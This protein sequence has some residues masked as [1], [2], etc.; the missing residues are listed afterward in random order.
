MKTPHLVLYVRPS[1]ASGARDLPALETAFAGL[2]LD[3]HTALALEI[4][5]TSTERQ[6]LL[7]AEQAAALSHLARQ[8]QGRY[9]QAVIEPASADPLVCLPGEACSVLELRPGAAVSLPLRSWKTRELILEGTDPL[10]GILAAFGALPP[11][12][13]AVAH[14]ALVPA[15]PIWSASSRRDMLEHPLPREGARTHGGVPEK[16][17]KDVLLL[18]PLVL[19]LF[20]FY[21]FH[22]LLPAFLLLAGE[23]LLRGQAPYLT[24]TETISVLLGAGVLLLVL[25]GG[26]SLTM[27]L[28]SRFGTPRIDDPRLVAEKTARPAYRVRL[29]LFVFAPAPRVRRIWKRLPAWF[30][31]RRV[32]PSDVRAFWRYLCASW[33]AFSQYRQISRAQQ[34]EREALLQTLAAS[35]RQYHLAAGGYFLP[36]MLSRRHV[37]RLLVPVARRWLRRSGWASDLLRSTHYLSV[38]DLAAL[39]HLPQA[40]DLLDLAYV[41]HATMR[42]LLSPSVLTQG[43]GYHLGTSTHAGHTLPVFLPFACLLQNV[44][45]VASTGKGK[46]NLLYHLTRAFALGRLLKRSDVPDGA[47]VIDF[48]GDLVRQ[49]SGSLP[50][51]LV[52]DMLLINLADRAYPIALNPLDMSTG[53]D[54]D[55]MID[56]LIAVVESLWSTSY[57]PRTE[58]FLEYSCKTLAEANLRLIANDPVNGPDRQ[59][60]LLDVV[61]LLRRT[62]FRNTVLEHVKDPFLVNWW[63]Q[64]YELLDARQQADFTSSLI[65][66]LAKFSSSQVIRRILGQ[67]RSTIDLS[68]LIRQNKIILFDCASGD[69]GVDMAALFGSLFVGF[70][71]TALQEQAQLRPEERHRFLVVIDEFQALAGIN[72]QSM[73]AELRKYGGSF[74]LATQS[75]AYLDRFDKTLR[76]TV[77][78]NMEHLFAF[79]IADEDARLLRLPGVEPED[80]VHLPNYSCYV[81]LALGGV[82]LPVFSLRLDAPVPAHEA[83]QQDIVN[84]CQRRYGRPVGEVDRLLQASLARQ[85]GAVGTGSGWDLGEVETVAEALERLNKKRKR[86]SGATKKEGKATDGGQSSDEGTPQHV[87]YD[88]LDDDL[89]L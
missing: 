86:G 73:L 68:D 63:H 16:S 2:A 81:R 89:P 75:M 70:F 26:V 56:N 10:L 84:Q 31:R 72:Y 17:F 58:S 3:E 1:R 37:R 22:G 51:E 46:S 34:K 53:K 61:P 88:N 9:P 11:G 59:Y 47:M 66:K 27:L 42:T 21:L 41:E 25:F 40:P 5:A 83:Q 24:T 13:R 82:R 39:W 55:K 38:A 4:A 8:I 15:S 50:P 19:V 28:V 64:Y 85:E 30:T 6:F 71:Q 77:L 57:G 23:R 12:T 78:A 18:F 43:Q 74:A 65:T 49:I 79:A 80:L 67:P 14:L 52:D 45:A 76:A 48:H 7:R 20:C 87:M 44:L 32:Q 62:S 36:R 69:I 29:R 35:Y 33:Q 54:R 60:T